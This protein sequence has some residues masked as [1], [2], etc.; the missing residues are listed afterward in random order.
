MAVKVLITD[1]NPGARA[2]IRSL[3]EEMPELEAV[4]E[5][6]G[7]GKEALAKARAFLPDVA[8]LDVDMPGLNGIDV[9][10]R[11]N[12]MQPRV[13]LV[14][15]TAYPEYALDAFEVYS[16]DYILKPI[17][18]ERVKK[19][20]RRLCDRM[21]SGEKEIADLVEA[22]NRPHRLA[23]RNGHEIIFIDV[24]SIIFMEKERKKTIIYTRDGRYDTYESLAELERRLNNKIFFRSHKSYLINLQ[25]VERIIPWSNGTYLIKFRYTNNDAL[26]SRAQAKI[27]PQVF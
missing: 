9:A 3:L 6:A 22:L 26:L 27:L 8:V 1:D 14:F 11:L 23:V 15:V 7:S 19:T 21:Q 24:D 20:F 17:D 16:F 13:Y 25:M 2:L 12:E 4:V 5:E 10:R 18:G